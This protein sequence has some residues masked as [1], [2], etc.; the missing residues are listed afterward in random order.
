M[1]RMQA[2]LQHSGAFGRGQ[3]DPP[4]VSAPAEDSYY[5]DASIAD[6]ADVPLLVSG[7]GH[8]ALA[9]AELTRIGMLFVRCRHGGISHSP[10]EAVDDAD[11]AAA[12]AALYSY[13]QRELQ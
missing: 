1:C 5:T 6:H 13:L 9:M 7:A 2:P 3:S 10:E 4:G 11:V 8:D 12:S